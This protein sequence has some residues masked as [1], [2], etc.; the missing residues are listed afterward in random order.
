MLQFG[1]KSILAVG[2]QGTLSVTAWV[3]EHSGNQEPENKEYY[4]QGGIV[5]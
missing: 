4:I 2:N 3:K 5:L 1:R